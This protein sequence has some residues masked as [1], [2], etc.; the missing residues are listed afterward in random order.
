[1]TENMCKWPPVHRETEESG[2]RMPAEKFLFPQRMVR[3]YNSPK[4][5]GYLGNVDLK[6]TIVTHKQLIGGLLIL[7][8]SAGHVMTANA[9]ENTDESGLKFAHM[10][11][12]VADMEKT[13]HFLTD[14]VGWKRHPIEFGVAADDPTTG[15]MEGRFFDANGLWLELIRPTSTGPGMD[16]LKE[17]GSGAI[18][19]INFLAP[20]YAATLAELKTKGIGMLNMDGSPL[21]DDGGRIKEAVEA[22]AQG[23][24]IAY[25]PKDVSRGSTV[26]ILELGNLLKTRDEMWKGV[27]PNPDSPRVS[28]IAIY[29]EDLEKSAAFYTDVMGLRRH[30]MTFEIPGADNPD[31][32]TLILGFIDAG[33]VWLEL[34]QPKGP[35]PFMDI[36]K[37]AGDGYLAELVIEVDDLGAYYDKMAAKGVRLRDLAFKPFKG[38]QKYV[39]EEPA[40]TKAA[41]FPTDVSQGM[42]IEVI[43][44]GPHATDF[45]HQRDDN[46]KR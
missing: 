17:K 29:V 38:N 30:P 4:P 10:V 8:F 11:Y 46:W 16:I 1:M 45:M 42:V 14:I 40:G 44:R 21:G 35:G 33:D 37:E 5:G 9:G 25:F 7:V 36:M 26:E 19:E 12:W 28:H 41:Y 31:I 24:R 27:K 18:I 6:E 13:S 20:D 15:G 39:V 23:E 32:G 22:G 3:A 2:H 34:V 43:E